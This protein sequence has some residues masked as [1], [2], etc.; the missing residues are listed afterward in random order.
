MGFRSEI[1]GGS[2][3][4]DREGGRESGGRRE[5]GR[6]ERREA[7]KEVGRRERD[8]DRGRAQ[9]REEGSGERPATVLRSV[10][11]RVGPRLSR[12]GASATMVTVKLR[13]AT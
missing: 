9:V 3:M 13:V 4:G 5:R 11:V 8:R 6:E 2:L 1:D 7:G 10:T 12:K